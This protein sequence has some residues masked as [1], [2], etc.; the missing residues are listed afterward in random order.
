MARAAS[1]SA[2][3]P[4]QPRAPTGSFAFTAEDEAG[5]R[6]V[7]DA[8]GWI[9]REVGLV[10]APSSI[11]RERSAA[12]ARRIADA[13]VNV[14]TM[15]AIGMDGEKVLVAFGVSDAAAARA[16]LGDAG[17]GLGPAVSGGGPR[18]GPSASA[19]NAG[20]IGH[21]A[22]QPER[23]ELLHPLRDR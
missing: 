11:G 3:S 1:T 9:Y 2:A 23:G 8:H 21:E 16:A 4:A 13:G 22:P 14:E 19:R 7:L 18:R 15:F 20:Q 5:A 6:A 10:V 12:A 17:G